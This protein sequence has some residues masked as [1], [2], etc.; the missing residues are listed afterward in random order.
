M[1]KALLLIGFTI[2]GTVTTLAQGY[3]DFS[4][5]GSDT[6]VGI[7]VGPVSSPSSQ[8]P[9]WYLAGDYSV[10]AFMASG[11]DQPFF[12]LAPV[13]STKTVFFGGPTTTAAGSPRTDGS[14]LWYAGPQD[15]GLPIGIATIQV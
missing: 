11:A 12:S 2:T 15:T 1:K 8:L 9:G 5:F 7:Q 4:W 6:G 13:A 14:G 10:E 3:I